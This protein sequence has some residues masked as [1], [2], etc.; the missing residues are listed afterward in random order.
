MQMFAVPKELKACLGILGEIRFRMEQRF[1]Q[2]MILSSIDVSHH[3]SQILKLCS[4][5]YP[6]QHM[7]APLI[8]GAFPLGYI[9]INIVGILIGSLE[10]GRMQ[11]QFQVD[12]SVRSVCQPWLYPQSWQ[13]ISFGER[14][15]VF[16]VPEEGEIIHHDTQGSCHA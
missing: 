1:H 13:R 8:L 7:C 6:G 11:S 12:L 5:T 15:R 16:I 3:H 10:D 4:S 14:T 9:M 2:L